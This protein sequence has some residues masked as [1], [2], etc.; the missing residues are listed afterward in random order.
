MN[1]FSTLINSNK[2]QFITCIG[3]TVVIFFLVFIHASNFAVFGDVDKP[4]PIG[5]CKFE[6]TPY[7]FEFYFNL[8]KKYFN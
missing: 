3:F 7:D 6:P 2:G 5:T 4:A 8:I 1:K